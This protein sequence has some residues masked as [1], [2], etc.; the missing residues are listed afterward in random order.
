MQVIAPFW[1]QES[2]RKITYVVQYASQK[3]LIIVE[4]VEKPEFA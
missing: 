4:A 1:I 3:N 2:E